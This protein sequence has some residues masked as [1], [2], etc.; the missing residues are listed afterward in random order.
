MKASR[1]LSLCLR[2][3]LDWKASPAPFSSWPCT[4]SARV[5]IHSLNKVQIHTHGCFSATTSLKQLFHDNVLWHWSVFHSSEDRITFTDEL[6][7]GLQ[8]VVVT[9]GSVEELLSN[10]KPLL[11]ENLVRQVGACFQFDICSEDGQ[12][13]TY[14]LDLSQGNGL[15]VAAN[16]LWLW[17]N[18]SI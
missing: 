10:V 12:Y 3:C 11:S 9:P 16:M 15:N 1:D 2:L 18:I 13:H 14:Y 6:S 5:A 8:S 7:S 4:F 17:D